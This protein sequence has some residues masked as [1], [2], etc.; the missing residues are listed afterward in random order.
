MRLQPLLEVASGVLPAPEPE[1]AGRQDVERLQA[2]IA[3]AAAM[4]RRHH[5]LSVSFG[6][7]VAVEPVLEMRGPAQQQRVQRRIAVRD[8]RFDR[9]AEQ[10]QAFVAAAAI[11]TVV[12]QRPGTARQRVGLP[13]L[14]RPVPCTPEILE[15]FVDAIQRRPIARPSV[16]AKL[17]Q[18]AVEVRRMRRLGFAVCLALKEPFQRHLLHQRVKVKA[19]LPSL[20]SN[21]LSV[22]A[23]RTGSRAPAT[24]RAAS[25]E[26][27]PANTDNRASA[28]RSTSLSRR[29]E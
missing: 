2:G 28:L 27:L 21:D 8:R 4:G 26:K 10:C 1:S 25:G 14:Y 20:I 16:R 15:L 24:A 23:A 18:Q 22:R 19:R 12:K 29:H 11:V 7:G 13:L 6:L 3:I 9:L 5:L 17:V